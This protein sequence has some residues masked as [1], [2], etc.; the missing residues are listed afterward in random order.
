MEESSQEE[1][2]D[3]IE[4]FSFNKDVYD[5]IK[6][7]IGEEDYA[8]FP[9]NFIVENTEY[10]EDI[11]R[12]CLRLR[13]Y[14]MKFNSKKECQKKNCCGYINYILNDVIRKYNKFQTS[15]FDIYIRYMNHPSNNNI[16]NLCASKITFIDEEKH[17]KM[18]K[19]YTAYKT[20]QLLISNERFTP[21]CSNAISCAKA[22]N[23]LKDTHINIDDTKFC[24]TLND[25][26]NLLDENFLISKGNCDSQI[27]N[28]I[29]Y[30]DS[31]NK[32][33][34]K[35]QTALLPLDFQAGELERTRKSWETSSPQI[36]EAVRGTEEHSVSPR[37]LDSTLPV[38]LFSSGI[39]L[40]LILLSFYKF[41]HF[42]HLL[43]LRMHNFIGISKNNDGEEYEM[44]QHNSEYEE[45]NEE[46][47]EYNISY[48]SL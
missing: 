9:D 33:L 48:N 45:R 24:K 11:T 20:C 23:N 14:I 3:S 19:L 44:Q 17:Q 13:K 43:K 6:R 40:V 15:I 21:S 38:T 26:K 36:E 31:C 34:E 30:P 4:D 29:S 47:D 42:G 12:D 1:R 22:F 25:F 2:Y 8:S 37:S 46:Y 32:I 7:N 39:G 5:K 27:P 41:T 16:N 18:D 35:T 28:L 10:T